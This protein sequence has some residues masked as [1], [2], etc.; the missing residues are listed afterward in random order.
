MLLGT[1]FYFLEYRLNKKQK[2]CLCKTKIHFVV[3][4][5]CSLEVGN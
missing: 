1:L 5:N 3:K 4:I 2:N